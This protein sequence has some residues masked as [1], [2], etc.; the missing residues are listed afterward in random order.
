MTF[1]SF[2]SIVRS[3][4]DNGFVYLKA[5]ESRDLIAPEGNLSEWNKAWYAFAASWDDLGE[6]LYM[7]DGGRYRRRRHA[8]MEACEGQ[9]KLLEGRPHYQS[10][11]YNPLNGGVERHFKPVLPNVLESPVLRSLMRFSFRMIQA[12]SGERPDLEIELHQFRIEVSAEAG[13][14]P[15]PEG[16]HRD[17]V[18]WVLVMLVNRDNVAEGETRLAGPDRKQ[19]GAFKL[20]QALDLVFLDDWRVFHGVTPIRP[21]DPALPG[22]R[23]VLVMTFR[24]LNAPPGAAGH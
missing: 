16:M 1:T 24:R 21:K 23:D 10:R 8:V 9:I 20:R 12:L 14:L 4:V 7:A 22:A 3:V 11:D 19:I 2:D 18:D 6:D 5:A 17:G 13:G 15:T